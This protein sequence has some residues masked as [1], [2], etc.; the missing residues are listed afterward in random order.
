MSYLTP[1][2]HRLEPVAVLKRC[3][4]VG[5][6]RG[7]NETVGQL[8]LLIESMGVGERSLTH[9]STVHFLRGEVKCQH[10]HQA[11]PESVHLPGT[12]DPSNAASQ[13]DW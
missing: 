8:E 1:S 3:E 9:L 4:Q 7:C 13:A 6:V 5:I 2:E 10:Q 12:N 11:T